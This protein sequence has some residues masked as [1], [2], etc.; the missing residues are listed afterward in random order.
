M[1]G[2]AAGGVGGRMSGILDDAQQVT[3]PGR[4]EIIDW[5][6]DDREWQQR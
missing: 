4:R 1:P 3:V 5:A 2:G 6:Q